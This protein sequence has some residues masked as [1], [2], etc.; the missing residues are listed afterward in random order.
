MNYIRIPRDENETSACL[1]LISVVTGWYLCIMPAPLLCT[2][3]FP[4]Q[5]YITWHLYLSPNSSCG[6]WAKC[7]F[8]L[9]SVDCPWLSLSNPS[10]LVYKFMVLFF[11]VL[12]NG[13]R[14]SHHVE[15]YFICLC[16]HSALRGRS[17]RHQCCQFPPP[18]FSP[19]FQ[20]TNNLLY[21]F[22]GIP[23]WIL[24]FSI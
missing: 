5:K 1:K 9:P 12:S 15:N 4:G 6:K 13:M 24:D 23:Q 22:S 3:L 2:W 14:E 16:I 21:W 20:R 11:L 19:N 7:L 8:S 17:H 10:I 18:R